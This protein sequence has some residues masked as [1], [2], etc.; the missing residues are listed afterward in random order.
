M[1]EHSHSM[2]LTIIPFKSAFSLLFGIEFFTGFNRDAFSVIFGSEF[3]FLIPG[4]SLT[5]L[6]LITMFLLNIASSL[7]FGST[8][9]CFFL[10]SYASCS[11]LFMV[12]STTFPGTSLFSLYLLYPVCW[13]FLVQTSSCRPLLTLNCLD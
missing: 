4:I 2:I 11:L 6:T 1:Q 3:Q 7:S 8:C 10:C 5:F 12:G 13:P 9:K